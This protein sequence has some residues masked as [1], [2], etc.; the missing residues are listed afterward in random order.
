MGYI[1]DVDQGMVV[2]NIRNKRVLYLSK[3]YHQFVGSNPF[4]MY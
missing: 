2:G 1:W 3:V 4:L